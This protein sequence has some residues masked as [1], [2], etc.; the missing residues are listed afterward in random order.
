MLLKQARYFVTVVD[1]GSFTEA[2]E[3]LFISQSAISQQIKAL[4]E[5]LGVQLMIRE[6]RKFSLTP[7]G[8]YF[9]RRCKAMVGEADAI[10]RETV[11]IGKGENNRLRVGYL[12]IVGGQALNQAVADFSEIYPDVSIT[13]SS[14]AHEELY[15]GLL[16][17]EL[18]MALNDQRRAFSDEYVNIELAVP[19]VLIEVSA[20]HYLSG[21]S[22]VEIEDLHALPCIVLAGMEQREVEQQYYKNILGFPGEFLFAESLESARLMVVSGQGFLPIE[23]VRTLPPV[24]AGTKRIPVL[25]HGAPLRRRYCAF[26]KK[27]RGNEFVETFA[28]LLMRYVST[29]DTTVETEE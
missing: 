23:D 3:R 1:E 10:V 5:D 6:K 18:D 4:E 27:E 21:L 12:N 28:E 11:R 22:Q 19:P 15:Y 29:A 14:G 17:H 26:W 24:S 25:R 20:R 9:Y 13:V 8:E 7:A 2:A 16:N